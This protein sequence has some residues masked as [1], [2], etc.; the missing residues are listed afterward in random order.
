MLS[1]N[2]TPAH[3]QSGGWLAL[4]SSRPI[5]LGCVLPAALAVVGGFVALAAMVS[6]VPALAWAPVRKE[7]LFLFSLSLLVVGGVLQARPL[8]YPVLL[9]FVLVRRA[10]C[11]SSNIFFAS[12][13]LYLAAVL[14]AY[15]V[16]AAHQVGLD[17]GYDIGRIIRAIALN[18]A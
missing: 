6:A 16:P 18:A 12:A 14:C 9:P 8:R 10:R 1:L 11:L 7:W 3:G 4:T 5:L 13:F 15:M 17:T 2:E